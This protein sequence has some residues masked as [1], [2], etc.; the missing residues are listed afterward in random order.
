MARLIKAD[1]ARQLWL[2]RTTLHKL[3]DQGTLSATRTHQT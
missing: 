1:A 3:L 2:S